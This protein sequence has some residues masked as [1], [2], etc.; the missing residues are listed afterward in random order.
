[1]GFFLPSNAKNSL[2][3][4]V[5][6]LGKG[7]REQRGITKRLRQRGLQVKRNTAQYL[8]LIVK[9]QINCTH[10]DPRCPRDFWDRRLLVTLPGEEC[11]GSI[12]DGLALRVSNITWFFFRHR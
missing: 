1:M 12:K 9:I 8:V 3:H 6:N 11:T 10:R 4:C 5:W 2:D 7:Q